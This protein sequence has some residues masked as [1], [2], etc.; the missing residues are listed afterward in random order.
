MLRISAWV[1]AAV[2]VLGAGRSPAEEK[3]TAAP[4]PPPPTP[5]GACTSC[6]PGP[7]CQTHQPFLLMDWLRQH[8]GCGGSECGGSQHCLVEWLSYRPLQ[9]WGCCC[10][11]KFAPCCT[12]PLYTYFVCYCY[13]SALSPCCKAGAA[14]GGGHALP[15]FRS[16]HKDSCATE[17]C[18]PCGAS[19][20]CES[21][22]TKSAGTGSCSHPWSVYRFLHGHP[23]T[24]GP[25][26]Q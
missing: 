25:C 9:P 12:P 7:A 3:S 26:V 19:A 21:C 22:K 4:T 18:P 15:L 14:C 1:T 17:S 10:G 24:E 23:C 6:G 11:S 8:S 13:G 2:L 20:S 5:C 16:L